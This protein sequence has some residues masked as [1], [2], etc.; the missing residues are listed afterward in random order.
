MTNHTT[1]SA[2]IAQTFTCVDVPA[3][4]PDGSEFLGYVSEEPIVDVTMT[5]REL[6][7][8]WREERNKARRRARRARLSAKHA[9]LNSI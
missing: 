2:L 8:A 3:W 5:R 1:L 4:T 6:R 7:H 9:F